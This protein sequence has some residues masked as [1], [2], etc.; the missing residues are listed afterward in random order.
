V[1]ARHAET[2]RYATKSNEGV[3]ESLALGTK[4][5][6][7]RGKGWRRRETI[8]L[9][10][11]YK[12]GVTGSSPVTPTTGSP[13]TTRANARNSHPIEVR[14]SVFGLYLVCARYGAMRLT[15]LSSVSK[16]EMISIRDVVEEFAAEGA[17]KQ[18]PRGNYVI[19]EGPRIKSCPR[20]EENSWHSCM[21]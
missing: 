13:Y 19:Y 15:L 20:C 2:G 11:P 17:L 6:T 18:A 9:F 8:G 21:C 3:D 5:N 12:A 7:P 16:V 14:V 10:C 4:G 1:S